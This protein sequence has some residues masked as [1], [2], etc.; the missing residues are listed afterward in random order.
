MVH[1]VVFAKLVGSNLQRHLSLAHGISEGF[2][3]SNLSTLYSWRGVALLPLFGILERVP[4]DSTSII[5]PK[6]ESQIKALMLRSL[7]EYQCP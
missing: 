3:P 6:P 7:G 2:C 1:E 5:P 4:V